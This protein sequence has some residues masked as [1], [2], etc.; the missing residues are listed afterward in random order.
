M[1][2]AFIESLHQS[3]CAAPFPSLLFL[4]LSVRHMSVG[5]F[6]KRSLHTVQS[7]SLRTPCISTFKPAPVAHFLP[8]VSLQEK[9]EILVE[10]ATRNKR[11]AITTVKGM[12]L[13]GMSSFP[14]FFCTFLKVN[15]EHNS[16][17]GFG[18]FSESDST[19]FSDQSGSQGKTRP[20]A[21]AL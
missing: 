5:L 13:F 3:L 1:F 20:S 11:K 21:Q 8:S 2:S 4:G 10:K 9:Q 16:R 14:P 17:V 19:L 18:P 12:E 15:L 7:S 6:F